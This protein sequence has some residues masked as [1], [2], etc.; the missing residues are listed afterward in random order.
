MRLFPRLFTL[1]Q[2]VPYRYRASHEHYHTFRPNLKGNSRNPETDVWVLA[3]EIRRAAQRKR[4]AWLTPYRPKSVTDQTLC[5]AAQGESGQSQSE[6]RD[7]CG[8]RDRSRERSKN[9]ALVRGWVP[10]VASHV[11]EHVDCAI[12]D[13]QVGR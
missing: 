2:I 6:E 7:R 8:L 1:R 4:A 11:I 10:N 9:V 12:G 3:L 13:D 5:A